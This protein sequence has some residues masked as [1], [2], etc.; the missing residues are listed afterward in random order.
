VE[1]GVTE[2]AGI[3][4]SVGERIRARRVALGLSQEQLAQALGVSYQQVQKY[5]NGS[6]R[7]AIGRLMAIAERLGVSVGVLSGEAA[8]ADEPGGIPAVAVDA[9]H[10]RAAVEAAR[11]FAAIRD[12]GVRQAL[13]TLLETIR[14]RQA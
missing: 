3:D 13:T 9:P 12:P 10:Q 1:D 6:N 4:R 2:G 8:P 11:G 14:E 7:I 5:E